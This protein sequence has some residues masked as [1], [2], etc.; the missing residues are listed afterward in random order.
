M[1]VLK[2]IYYDRKLIM[3]YDEI[4]DNI[5]QHAHLTKTYHVALFMLTLWYHVV[6]VGVVAR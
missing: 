2:N 4:L 5:I 6:C 3:L 1:Y